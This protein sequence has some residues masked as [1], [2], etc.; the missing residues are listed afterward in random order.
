MCGI[1]CRSVRRLHCSIVLL[2]TRWPSRVTIEVDLKEQSSTAVICLQPTTRRGI[3][4]LS[5]EPLQ[6]RPQGSETRSFTP[7]QH[8]HH[9]QDV[10]VPVCSPPQER[11]DH[12]VSTVGES[13]EALRTDMFYQE[14]GSWTMHYLAAWVVGLG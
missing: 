2:P 14:P 12:D 4:R 5:H 3:L 7:R 10:D 13:N 11:T 1:R 6:P 8:A 9:E